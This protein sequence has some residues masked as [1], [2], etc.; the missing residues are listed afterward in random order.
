MWKFWSRYA[1]SLAVGLLGLPVVADAEALDCVIEP[2][3]TVTLVASEKGRIKE[4]L[5][6]RGDIVT[7]GQVL[8]RLEDDVQ[9]L[10]VE[11]AKT[12]M[13]SDLEVRAGETRLV[14]RE[15]D[16]ARAR[17]LADR[18]VAAVTQ[19]E[20]AEIEVALTR[21]AIEQARLAQQMAR[22]E[23]QQALALLARRTMVS[24]ADGVVTSVEAAPGAFASEQLQILTIAVID[25]LH[26][27]VFATPEYFT[28]VAVGDVY[29]V[30][31]VSPLD[32]EFA[33][34][35]SVVDRVFD[36]AS[37]TFGVQLEI[38][39][40]EGAIP[41]GTRCVVDFDAKAN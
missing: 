34:T 19:V 21:V 4:I 1:P 2:R 32:G 11:M 3:A 37:G 29:P 17:L 28:R 24:P 39:N 9:R 23:H 31:Q 27:E 10:Q 12:R 33:A 35:V 25:P 40:P 41:A 13:E 5:A 7:Q 20:D 16:R 6:A 15:K 26:V 14:Q 8:V 30:R 36:A 38:A 22:I 18:N